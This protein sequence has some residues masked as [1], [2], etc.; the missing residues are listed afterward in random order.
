VRWID[1]K[2]KKKERKKVHRQNL[3]PSR[4]T[5]GSLKTDQF[6]TL[7]KDDMS[8]LA[9]LKQETSQNIIL[10]VQH[11]ANMS[12]RNNI[13]FCDICCFSSVSLLMSSLKD[14]SNCEVSFYI[15]ICYFCYT[16]LYLNAKFHPK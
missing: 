4:L 1:K 6:K 3:S 2:R 10:F 11:I 13:I 16:I 5:S 15:N 8:K 9:E 14:V 12:L 7:F